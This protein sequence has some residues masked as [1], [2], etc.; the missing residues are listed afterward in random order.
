ME[1][2]DSSPLTTQAQ[3]GAK[4]EVAGVGMKEAKEDCDSQSRGFRFLQTI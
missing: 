4:I 2:V 1:S 3:E